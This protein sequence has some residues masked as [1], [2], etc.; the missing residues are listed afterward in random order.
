MAAVQFDNGV[1]VLL[2]VSAPRPNTAVAAVPRRRL[3]LSLRRARRLHEMSRYDMA[4]A[5]S[6]EAEPEDHWHDGA[7]ASLAMVGVTF[8]R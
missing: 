4:P 2:T 5:A 6:S 8:R 7:R 3:G 1:D